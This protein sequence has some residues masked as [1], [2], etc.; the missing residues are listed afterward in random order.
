MAKSRTVDDMGEAGSKKVHGWAI[1]AIRE[2]LSASQA[3][4]AAEAGISA[5]FLS[6]IENG[7][8]PAVSDGTFAGLVR[9]LR[10]RDKRAILATPCRD[11]A[12]AE[13]VAS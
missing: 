6:Q 10:I 11:C 8:R 12:D 2:A 13:Q 3:D 7:V 9:A 1:K 4:V 5:P